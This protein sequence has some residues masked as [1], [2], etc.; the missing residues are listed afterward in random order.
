MTDSS[1]STVP[2]QR[3][4][5]TVTPD[6]IRT[7]TNQVNNQY[8]LLE[9]EVSASESESTSGE[10]TDIDEPPALEEIQLEEIR[11]DLAAAWIPAGIIELARLQVAG[12][13][14]T[15]VVQHFQ[16]PPQRQRIIVNP[17]FENP[18]AEIRRA[19]AQEAQYRLQAPPRP[20]YTT[21]LST[22]V[23]VFGDDDDTVGTVESDDSMSSS[24]NLPSI[25]VH[26][27]SEM[28]VP[29]AEYNF[30]DFIV[31][32]EQLGNSLARCQHATRDCGHSPLVDTLERHRERTGD[33]ATMALP[34][35]A[36]RPTIPRSDTSGAWRRYEVERKMH[37]QE[38]HWNNEAIKAT[39]RRFPIAVQEQKDQHDA[40]PINYT[41]RKLLNYIED[42]VSDRVDMQKANKTIMQALMKR[43][44]VPDTDGPVKFFKLMEHDVYRIHIL[45]FA[46]RWDTLIVHCQTT[47]RDSN[48]H[49]GSNLRI[50]ED[51]WVRR[52]PEDT[53]SLTELELREQW[54]R[55]KSYYIKELKKLATDGPGGGVAHSADAL[56]ARM[57]EFETSLT[58]SMQTLNDNQHKLS[59]AYSGL[60]SG[61]P[62]I[63]ETLND[64]ST[65]G[66]MSGTLLA[67]SAMT[68]LLS[69]VQALKQVVKALSAVGSSPTR[70]SPRPP[71]RGSPKPK[72][73]ITEWR[74][75]KHWCHSCGVNLNHDSP[76]CKWQRLPDHKDTATRQNPM[77]GPMR[78][79]TVKKDRF[80]MKWCCPISHTA[81][82]KEGGD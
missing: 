82:S 13:I 80:W 64:T 4:A 47:I 81:H 59:T 54:E 71:A 18:Q 17:R 21:R 53:S 34:P 24:E 63:V 7:E 31:Y 33:G 16:P 39:E 20:I 46:Y 65:V 23:R 37:L 11:R 42:K 27:P 68:D 55:F 2:G 40:L 74:Q 1:W 66:T 61:V 77:G 50:I 28:K 10:D 32:K 8:Q 56:D 75:W 38:Q 67:S 48:R 49:N 25:D 9:D 3:Q 76:K 14:D 19:I 72:S 52:E 44:Y 41:I 73:N 45:K 12:L 70:P 30:A 60:Q 43:A 35:P 79:N 26:L 58:A 5:T 62:S 36:L 57:N 51:E 6:S 22:V 78:P 15:G 69:E 29:M